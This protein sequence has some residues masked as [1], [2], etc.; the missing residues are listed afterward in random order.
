MQKLEEFLYD[1]IGIFIP[2]FF[3]CFS[4]WLATVAL[5][6]KEVFQY[7]YDLFAPFHT[8]LL[9]NP[10]YPL[11][12]AVMGEK[13]IIILVVIIGCYVVGLFLSD[14]SRRLLNRGPD[15]NDQDSIYPE[16]DQIKVE[17][18]EHFASKLKIDLNGMK[19]RNKWITFYRWANLLSAKA[20]EKS[21]LSIL[22]AKVTLYRSLFLVLGIAGIYIGVLLIVSLVLIQNW[23]WFYILAFL[24]CAALCFAMSR[25]FLR[26]YRDGQKRLC[27][28]C[29]LILFKTF[30]GEL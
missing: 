6:K 29:V 22:L 7:I 8:V 18:E 20:E 15:S 2:G 17:V 4:L 16:N 11:V 9:T 19:K 24:L 27:N 25:F 28:E 1:F 30:K 13:S 5:M 26:I 10:G 21:S 12:K 23:P 3:M 14:F